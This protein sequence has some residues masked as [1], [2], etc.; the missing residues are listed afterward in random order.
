MGLF[1]QTGRTRIAKDSSSWKV[2]VSKFFVSQ[3]MRF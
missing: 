2:L 3:V 1:M